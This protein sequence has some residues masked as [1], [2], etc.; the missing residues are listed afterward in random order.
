MNRNG[1]VTISVVFLAGFLCC[2]IIL[3]GCSES[4]ATWHIHA[5]TAIA[6]ATGV[7]VI[8]RL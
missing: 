8:W 6:L 4:V 5:I 2:E 1:K 7:F 3:L